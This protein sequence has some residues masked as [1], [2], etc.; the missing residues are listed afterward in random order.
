[1]ADRFE[2]DIFP[3]YPPED[4]TII[5]GAPEEN[6]Y[7]TPTGVP[8]QTQDTALTSESVKRRLRELSEGIDVGK[9]IWD[10]EE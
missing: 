5:D 1:L 4:P 9:P 3:H 2:N 10:S 6:Y 8:D 7:L